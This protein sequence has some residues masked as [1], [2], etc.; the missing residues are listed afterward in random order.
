MSGITELEPT[1]KPRASAAAP[2]STIHLEGTDAHVAT[3][4]YVNLEGK[5]VAV[6]LTKEPNSLLLRA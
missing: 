3:N 1:P 6:K 4:K 2:P 5:I